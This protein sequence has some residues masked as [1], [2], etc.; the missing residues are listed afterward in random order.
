MTKQVSILLSIIIT[1]LILT[2]SIEKNYYTT[3]S[4]LPILFDGKIKP[5]NSFSKS[6][7][8]ELDLNNKNYSHTELLADLLFDFESFSKLDIFKIKNKNIINN[9]D[10]HYKKNNQYSINELMHSIKKKLQYD[11]LFTKDR[12]R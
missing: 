4:K 11:K 7:F 8:Q 9:L 3:F 6:L 1:C 2:T 10:L 5:L 12:L